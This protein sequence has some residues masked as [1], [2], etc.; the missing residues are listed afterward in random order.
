MRGRSGAGR[1]GLAVL[2]LVL[3]LAT[4]LRAGAPPPAAWIARMQEALHR[5]TYEGRYV[6]VEPPVVLAFSVRHAPGWERVGTL[7][8]PRHV[9]VRAGHWTGI[10]L[11]G[12]RW[13]RLGAVPWYTA[14]PPR[15]HGT[16][17]RDLGRYYRMRLVGRARV[18]GR[19]AALLVV[20][21]RDAYRYGYRFWVAT[22][23]GLPLRTVLVSPR[24]RVLEQMMFVDISFPARIAPPRLLQWIAR[25]GRSGSAGGRA[26]AVSV[27]DCRPLWLPPGFRVMSDTVIP[28]GRRAEPT[29]H[30]LLSDGLASFSVFVRR[31]LAGAP[32]PLTGPNS[33]GPVSAYGRVVGDYSLTVVGEVPPATVRATAEHLVLVPPPPP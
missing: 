13:V 18:A 27:P 21:P 12:H 8:G 29:R 1:R 23:T 10:E 31:L 5:L 33:L 20:A 15:G 30:L 11:P 32:P 16:L 6:F 22:R 14:L 24:G 26:A 28:E 25:R 19:T 4:G 17:D 2:A 9:L 7:N 3:L